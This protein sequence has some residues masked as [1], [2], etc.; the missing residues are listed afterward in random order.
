M[1]DGAEGYVS[2]VRNAGAIFVGKYTPEAI[3]DYVA[4]PSHV[5]PTSSSARFSSGLSVYDFLKRVSV[6]GCD[7][8]S[9]GRL[10][11]VTDVLAEAEGLGA[12]GLSIQVRKK[13]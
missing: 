1:V 2:K 4:G 8:A 5:L 7:E 3:G 11:E 13:G 10:A 12:H 6:I 9:F